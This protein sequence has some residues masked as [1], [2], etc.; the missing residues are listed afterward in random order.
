MKEV[1]ARLAALLSLACVL[2]LSGC[3]GGGGVGG[4]V[5]P[6]AVSVASPSTPDEARGRGY[7][8]P[9]EAE[10]A[11]HAQAVPPVA[12]VAPA[13]AAPAPSPQAT[14]VTQGTMKL[15]P[16]ELLAPVG[17]QG[18]DGSCLAWSWGYGLLTCIV[19]RAAP[20][21]SQSPLHQAN[22]LFLYTAV[23][24]AHG[25]GCSGGSVFREYT[26][27][28]ETKGGWSN[29][30]LPRYPRGT[31]AHHAAT[32]DQICTAV[33]A[34]RALQPTPTPDPQFRVPA[35]AIVNLST[36][37]A[38]D[39]GL[40]D[41]A[42]SIKAA[43]D[44]NGLPVAIGIFEPVGLNGY[45]GGMLNAQW[46]AR[47]DCRKEGHGMLVVGYDDARV[48]DPVTSTPTPACNGAPLTT[49]DWTASSAPGAFLVQNSWGSA[50]GELHPSPG[51]AVKPVSKGYIWM[52]YDTI[53]HIVTH[54]QAWQEPPTADGAPF[55][56]VTGASGGSGGFTA[57][58]PDA[59]QSPSFA[60]RVYLIIPYRF[61]QQVTIERFTLRTPSGTTFDVP[62]TGVF[63]AGYLHVSRTDAKAWPS[64]VY[65]LTL[66]VRDAAGA[67]LTIT[68]SP[69]VHPSPTGLSAAE[70]SGRLINAN[71]QPVDL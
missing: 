44:S 27:L 52:S 2:L 38:T 17:N 51:S 22:P 30:Q 20:A 46:F 67:V 40:T 9:T 49:P 32:A 62:H 68:A 16:W 66:Q 15:V 12:L 6:T 45:K 28:F 61:S 59:W 3:S 63:E 33:D 54:A 42:A 39:G 26:A 31:E 43:I 48:P 21:R 14:P 57:R 7:E 1:P 24:D 69:T 25:G 23:K 11:L 70:P 4:A 10:I 53:R 60:G 64:G 55:A 65:T 37:T 56:H 36:G 13:G 50:W 47:K 5:V 29:A 35:G 19:N 41:T 58:F 8:P 18:A 34:V 71:G